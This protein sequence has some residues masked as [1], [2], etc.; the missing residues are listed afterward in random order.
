M[1]KPADDPKTD[2]RA[3]VAAGYDACAEAFNAARAADDDAVL[4]PLFDRVPAG[5]RVLDLGCGGGVPIARSLSRRY[6]TVGVDISRAQLALAGER[7][8]AARLV[9]ADMTRLH[10]TPASFDAIVSLYAIFH[11]P[12]NEHAPLLARV[13]DW[14]RPGGCLLASFA[15]AAEAA[16]TEEFFGV[17]MYWSNYGMREYRE[18]LEAA[19]FALLAEDVLSHGYGDTESPA[20]SHPLVLAVRR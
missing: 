7:V 20:E 13:H 12:R 1:M 5:S 15:G 2:Y 16:Y 3:L 9:R 10:F 19:G 11:T 8:P 6:E 4:R 14:L 17:E 18:M